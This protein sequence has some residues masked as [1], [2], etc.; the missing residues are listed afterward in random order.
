MGDGRVLERLRAA[1]IEVAP[2][3]DSPELRE[4]ISAL[5]LAIEQV[6]ELPQ[7]RR[8]ALLSLR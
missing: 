7:G 5:P 2:A 1:G 6:Y 3:A 4:L 8:Y